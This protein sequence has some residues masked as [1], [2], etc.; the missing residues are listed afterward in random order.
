MTATRASAVSA[1]DD[2]GIANRSPHVVCW[3]DVSGVLD[4]HLEQCIA[5]LQLALYRP[6]GCYI[7][8]WGMQERHNARG[9]R[10]DEN[11]CER[12]EAMLALRRN[13][14]GAPDVRFSN[15][16]QF[17]RCAE[18]GND[19]DNLE[20]F[21]RKDVYGQGI[22]G[23]G[24]PYRAASNSNRRAVAAPWFVALTAHRRGL[25]A[26]TFDLIGRWRVCKASQQATAL[27]V[28]SSESEIQA[29]F[30]DEFGRCVQIV[31]EYYRVERWTS[32]GFPSRKQTMEEIFPC[33][34]CGS[35]VFWRDRSDAIHCSA[36]EPAHAA[37]LIRER[38]RA[39]TT[40]DTQLRRATRLILHHLDGADSVAAI[41]VVEAA[42]QAKVSP[43]T[44]TRARV[45]F[46]IRSKQTRQGWVWM[47]PP[48]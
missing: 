7:G 17:A 43:A 30:T 2:M 38:L 5:P 40:A 20:C 18:G 36:C 15:S 4:P 13:Y 45:R 23:E 10:R 27:D 41:V 34:R 31:S 33:V 3:E 12:P 22:P 11:G 29:G 9:K 16:L 35:L 6:Y 32:R 1:S 28:Q 42:A 24:D 44:L 8:S 48:H 39:T 47:K 21:D 14:G 19:K 37:W 46:R 25:L 26:L